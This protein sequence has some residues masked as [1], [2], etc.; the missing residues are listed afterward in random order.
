MRERILR[1]QQKRSEG[2]LG[3]VKRRKE[4]QGGDSEAREM[5][6]ESE[7]LKIYSIEGIYLE[8]GEGDL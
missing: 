3:F 7:G 6:W 5:A 2:L 1:G 8:R 4:I